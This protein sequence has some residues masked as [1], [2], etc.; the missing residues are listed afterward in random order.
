[1]SEKEIR[2]L[3][4]LLTQARQAETQGQFGKK[5]KIYKALGEFIYAV[6]SMD[7][8]EVKNSDTW[9]DEVIEI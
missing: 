3:K 5:Y 8:I 1:M 2:R 9:Y 7:G 6:A 4:E